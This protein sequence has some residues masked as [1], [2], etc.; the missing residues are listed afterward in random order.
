VKFEVGDI[1][2]VK[3]NFNDNWWLEL[4][5]DIESKIENATKSKYTRTIYLDCQHEISVG[6]GYIWKNLERAR[7]SFEIVKI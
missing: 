4:I 1:I 7:Y 5:V 6:D 3:N 2:F